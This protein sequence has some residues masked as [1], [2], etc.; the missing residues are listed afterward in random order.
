MKRIRA[1]KEVIREGEVEWNSWG[2]LGRGG[3][4]RRREQGRK[5]KRQIAQ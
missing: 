4:E 5:E 2:Q 3:V 1:L